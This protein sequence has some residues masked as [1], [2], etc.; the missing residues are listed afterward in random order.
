MNNE[1]NQNRT[2]VQDNLRDNTKGVAGVVRMTR[3]IRCPI[4]ESLT[5]H[6]ITGVC[7]H[8]NLTPAR[9]IDLV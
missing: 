6:L 5:E 1:P 3:V 9:D 2:V 4:R 8:P 7:C